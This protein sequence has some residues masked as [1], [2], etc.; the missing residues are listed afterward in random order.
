[1]NFK[2]LTI[3][4]LEKNTTALNKMLKAYWL[5]VPSDTNIEPTKIQI[6]E[7]TNIRYKYNKLNR[8]G[9]VYGCGSMSKQSIETYIDKVNYLN[10]K[11][12]ELFNSTKK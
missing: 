3:E 2:N 5:S 6:T 10:E 11:N 4:N 9:I 7:I 12:E 1:M 8:N